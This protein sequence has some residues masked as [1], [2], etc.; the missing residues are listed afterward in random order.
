MLAL[1]TRGTRT[2]SFW[3]HCGAGHAC[4]KIHHA[5]NMSE[6]PRRI[7]DDNFYATTATSG[8][9]ADAS[10]LGATANGPASIH[11][12]ATAGEEEWQLVVSAATP[13]AKAVAPEE[14]TMPGPRPESAHYAATSPM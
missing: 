5:P 14:C 7:H 9:T 4:C 2:S 11:A 3:D 8:W 13:L 10:W 1:R 6:A 12:L